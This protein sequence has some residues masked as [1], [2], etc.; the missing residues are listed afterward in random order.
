MLD[1][2]LSSGAFANL[3][4]SY[5]I[6]SALSFELFDL[7]ARGLVIINDLFFGLIILKSPAK[8]NL[9]FFNYC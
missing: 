5:E 8:D 3:L 4:N 7:F 1:S 6:L 9:L 2:S